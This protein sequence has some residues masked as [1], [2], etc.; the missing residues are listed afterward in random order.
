MQAPIAGSSPLAGSFVTM[1]SSSSPKETPSQSATK[2]SAPKIRRFTSFLGGT[3]Q[4]ANRSPLSFRR[5]PKEKS[6]D[7]VRTV[8]LLML[9]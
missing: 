6:P 7:A 2:G 9:C 3:P 1:G 8:F 5:T 4:R